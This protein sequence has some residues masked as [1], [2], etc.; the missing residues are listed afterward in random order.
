MPDVEQNATIW[1]NSHYALIFQAQDLTS[2]EGYSITWQ[3]A[4]TVDDEPVIE[5]T[6]YVETEID[7]IGNIFRVHITPEDTDPLNPG[8]Y[9]H[10]ARAT[11]SA[12]KSRPVSLGWITLRESYTVEVL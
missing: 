5:K 6:Q 2:L 4:P 9:Y 12:N 11:D 10:E 8:L 3:M 7:I 1:K